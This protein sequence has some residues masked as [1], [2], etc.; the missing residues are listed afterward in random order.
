MADLPRACEHRDGFRVMVGLFFISPFEAGGGH[1][2]A[3]LPRIPLSMA[4]I[5]MLI[6]SFRRL[7]M[8]IVWR[9]VLLA[10]GGTFLCNAWNYLP[11]IYF[12]THM[13]Y[14]IKAVGHQAI[15]DAVRPLTDMGIYMGLAML[16]IVAALA[17]CFLFRRMRG[18][19][20]AP[21][22]FWMLLLVSGGLLWLTVSRAFWMAVGSAAGV[23]QFPFR[24]GI[25]PAV[26]LPLA[27]AMGMERISR[28]KVVVPLCLLLCF[29]GNFH[30]LVANDDATLLPRFRQMD[31]VQAA[32]ARGEH[33]MYMF[34]ITAEGLQHFMEWGNTSYRDY[35]DAAVMAESPSQADLQ[36]KTQK[37]DII[38]QDRIAQVRRMGTGRMSGDMVFTAGEGIWMGMAF[39]PTACAAVWQVLRWRSAASSLAHFSVSLGITA[40]VWRCICNPPK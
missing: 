9:A 26:F 40:A 16:V 28:W 1:S 20:S 33:P 4:D 31:D 35:A 13:D 17:A 15:A 37:H 2:D 36:R 8:R 29:C 38:P 39:L 22:E 5:I 34:E 14:V 32:Q 24:L 21:A 30:W 19:A 12:H 27:L 7:R 3:F 6:L 25:F 11:L 10:I 23:L 18:L